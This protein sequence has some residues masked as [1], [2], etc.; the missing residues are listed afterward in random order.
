M[1]EGM[2]TDERGRTAP[3]YLG[4]TVVW[5]FG[6]DDERKRYIRPQMSSEA[7]LFYL[8]AIP[9]FFCVVLL[10]LGFLSR[11]LLIVAGVAMLVYA[12]VLLR[13]GRPKLAAL[14]LGLLHKRLTLVEVYDR[15]GLFRR[16]VLASHRA[17]TVES[18]GWVTKGCHVEFKGL[19][20]HERPVVLPTGLFSTQKAID[21]LYEWARVHGITIDGVPPL[22]GAYVRQIEE[23]RGL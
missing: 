21:A 2:A 3:A 16:R 23:R 6:N 10:A 9:V 13:R 8:S 7:S 11:Y 4:E 14:E 17:S 1:V 5:T 15:P 12:G 19:T 18:M 20:L 22:P